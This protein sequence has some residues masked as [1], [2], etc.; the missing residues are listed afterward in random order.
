[1]YWRK[2]KKL[3]CKKRPFSKFI[4]EDLLIKGKQKTEKKL[5]QNKIL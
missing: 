3:P 1:M 5:E 4:M 2:E